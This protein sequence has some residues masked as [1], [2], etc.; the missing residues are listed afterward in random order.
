M[1][2]RSILAKLLSY[3]LEYVRA[4]LIGKPDYTTEEIAYVNR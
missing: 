1:R 2:I 3:H 4:F